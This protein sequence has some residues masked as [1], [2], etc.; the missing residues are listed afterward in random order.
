MRFERENGYID[1]DKLLNDADEDDDKTDQYKDVNVDMG[2]VNS[3][4]GN[5]NM[6]DVDDEEN[7]VNA[8]LDLARAYIEIEDQ[9]SARALLKEVQMDG[10]E[11]QQ[12][13][14]KNLL[15]SVN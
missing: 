3:L 10:N 15:K 11:R 12:L 13:E 8:K 9:D 14:A 5:P 7:S 2:S 6:I 1:I 4:I